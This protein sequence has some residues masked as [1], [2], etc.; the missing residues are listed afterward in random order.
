MCDAWYLA[1]ADKPVDPL[2][3][4]ELRRNLHRFKDWKEARMALELQ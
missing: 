2:S 4:E 3:I 1:E